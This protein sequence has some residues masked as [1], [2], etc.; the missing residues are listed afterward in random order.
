M[1][2]VGASETEPFLSPPYTYRVGRVS[3]GGG[4]QYE[5]P[6][7]P[8]NRGFDL[9]VRED[10]PT[11]SGRMSGAALLISIAVITVAVVALVVFVFMR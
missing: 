10:G 11:K 9:H 2:P 3:V 1:Y 5:R 6:R 8:Q 4:P 7:P